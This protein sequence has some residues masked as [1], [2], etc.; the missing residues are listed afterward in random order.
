VAEFEITGGAGAATFIARLHRD[1][2][3]L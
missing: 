1:L 2:Q 3:L